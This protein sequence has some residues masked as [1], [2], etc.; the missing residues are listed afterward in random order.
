M[1]NVTLSLDDQ[2][3]REARIVAAERGT[4]LS[5]LV[6]DYLRSLHSSRP[7]HEQ[8]VKRMFAAMDSV[9]SKFGAAN[10]MTRDEVH[11]RKRLR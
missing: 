2:T 4:S 10:R 6:R 11:D 7:S 3:W 1:K 9:K 8:A 5:A